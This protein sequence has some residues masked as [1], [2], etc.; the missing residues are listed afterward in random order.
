MSSTAR[1]G[2]VC[3]ASE[4]QVLGFGLVAATCF[5][6]KKSNDFQMSMLPYFCSVFFNYPA[7]F[8]RYLN[9]IQL[10]GFLTKKQQ[11]QRGD[12]D[13]LEI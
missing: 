1:G 3:G 4:A 7:S 11:D 8:Q 5:A 2:L 9:Q 13:I 10:A 6:S 12:V